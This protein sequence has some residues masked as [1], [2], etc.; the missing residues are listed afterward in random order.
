MSYLGNPAS[1]AVGHKARQMRAQAASTGTPAPPTDSRLI[2]RAATAPESQ[3][4]R[5]AQGKHAISRH[6]GNA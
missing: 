1:E 6:K 4:V 2:G 3:T 5:R